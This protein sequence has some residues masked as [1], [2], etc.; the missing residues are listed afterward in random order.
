MKPSDF[1]EF[2]D[3]EFSY[4]V[5]GVRDGFEK[6]D[7]II[8]EEKLDAVPTKE[9]FERNDVQRRIKAM[10]DR[11]AARHKPPQVMTE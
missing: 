2:K 10:M 8:A 3:V 4:Q 9:D 5:T 7:I 1:S 11:K 6:Q